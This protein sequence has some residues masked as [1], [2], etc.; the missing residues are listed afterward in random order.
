MIAGFE[1]EAAADFLTLPFAL[2]HEFFD[3]P[4]HRSVL[5]CVPHLATPRL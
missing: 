5:T 2:A 4:P 3:N 1:S